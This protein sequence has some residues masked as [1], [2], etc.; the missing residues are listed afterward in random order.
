MNNHQN[1]F[2][3]WSANYKTKNK[4]IQKYIN[5][6]GEALASSNI[7]KQ[8]KYGSKVIKT[9]GQ[10]I[11]IIE[12]SEDTNFNTLIKQATNIS[13]MLYTKKTKLDKELVE[14]QDNIDDI[15]ETASFFNIIA[16]LIA[17]IGGIIISTYTSKNIVESLASFQT[18]LL[19][20]FR[21]VNKE[22]KDIQLI[23]IK[24]DD[25]FGQM[26]KL[27]NENIIKT[28]KYIEENQ[29][30]IDEV[31]EIS[32]SIDNGYLDKRIQSQSSDETL[33]SLKTN[34]NSMLDNLQKHIEVILATFKEYE[35]N[36]FTTQNKISCDGEIR[37]LLDGVNSLGKVISEMLVENMKNGFALENSSKNLVFRVDGLSSSSNEQAVALK[38]TAAS[39]EEITS[40]IQQNTKNAVDMANYAVEVRNSTNI[41]QNLANQ[42]VVSM[43]EINEQ[44]MAI[45]D[46]ISVIDQIAFQTNILSLNA[47]VEAATAGE[48][49]K[50]FAVVA[51]EVRNLASRSAEAAKEIKDLVE[52]A[53]TKAHNG[54]TIATQMIDGYA[55]LN[56][57]IKNTMNLIDE[58]TEASKEQQKGIEQIND[59]INELDKKTQ[60]NAAVASDANQIALQTSQIA[61]T[62]VDD[63]KSKEFLGKESLVN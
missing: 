35:S 1:E 32:N 39:L 15:V 50:G 3:N 63:A 6:Y 2:L 10:T 14:A 5:R 40:N 11:S 28:R 25:E 9:A 19:E 46:A 23:E 62:I 22:Q 8:N 55:N 47:A 31:V 33:N 38:E 24:S 44:V 41:G 53:T 4:R 60:E 30:L 56:N 58:V 26:G 59:T 18:S 45:N 21:F 12:A 52:N 51:Q 48:A 29:Q 27:L 43:D 57:N 16:A 61:K 49:G 42:T 17:V 20:F 7:E 36:R 54:K 37:E 13:N 34:F